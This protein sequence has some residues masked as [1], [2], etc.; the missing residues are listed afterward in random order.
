MVAEQQAIEHQKPERRNRNQQRGEASGNDLLRVR[1]REIAAHQK[2][3]PDSREMAKLARGKTY[4]A[5][6]QRAVSE[7][8]H[9]RNQRSAWRT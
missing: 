5:S 1:K 2:Q 8:D 4:A 6:G 3:N 7:H 9:A